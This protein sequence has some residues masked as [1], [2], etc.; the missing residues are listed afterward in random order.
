M[1]VCLKC[2]FV[3][4][5]EM[6]FALMQNSC[7]SCGSQLFSPEDVSQI[8]VLQ[9]KI[10][11]QKFSED[12]STELNYDLSLFIYHELKSGLGKT[13]TI[14]AMEAYRKKLSKTSD[15]EPESENP[16]ETTFDEPIADNEVEDMLTIARKEVERELRPKI[17]S[18]LKNKPRIEQDPD[19][20]DEYPEED[21]EGEELDDKIER[22][23]KLNQ[24]RSGGKIKKS[25]PTPGTVKP[26]SGIKRAQ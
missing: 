14:A 20:E 16:E 18:I 25:E 7:P 10:S 1:I 17:N 3:V 13:L 23:K 9:N 26:F 21:V 6:K 2:K 4:N 8:Q 11:A 24:Q 22:L 12:F 19:L 5:N 15:K